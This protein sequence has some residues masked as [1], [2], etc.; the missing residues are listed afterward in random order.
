MRIA[1]L[2]DIHANREAFEAVLADIAVKKPD[3]IV[4]LGDYV[5]YGADPTWCVD[6][7]MELVSQGAVAV[8]GN[9]DAAVENTRDQMTTNA[10]ITLA[11]TR[12]ELG[13]P[14]REFLAKLPMEVSELPMLFVHADASE[15]ASWNYVMDG[16]DA[17]RSLKGSHAR[18][19][20]VGH[21]HRPAIY[22]LSETGK[23]TQFIPVTD[24]AVP[25]LT[26]RR[27][28][29]VVGSVGQP[30]DGVPAAAYSIYDTAKH[31]IVSV[32]VP[33]DIDTAAGKIRKA[34]LP[35]A[36]ARRLKSG[37]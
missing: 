23:L 32:R 34:G 27:W 36:L 9:H 6:K 11:F 7:V 13:A 3:R 12:G 21:V 15:P 24:V 17:S 26:L 16:T 18:V 25:L 29:V 30:R 4:L 19:T 20:F 1:L 14:Q 5:G 37:N 22:A 2:T 31:D 28:L 8:M 10:Q 33:Y 35:E